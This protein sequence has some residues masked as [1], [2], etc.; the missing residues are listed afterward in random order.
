MTQKTYLLSVL[1]CKV[2]DSICTSPVKLT[3][4]GF[5]GI[6]LH[7]ILG[8]NGTKLR[9][10]DD[11]LLGVV[12]ADRQRSAD[13]RT[14]SRLDGSIKRCSCLLPRV[15]RRAY[16]DATKGKKSTECR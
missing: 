8:R 2:R 14:A 4:V 12:I 1:G 15:E 7:R 16:G 3:P 11:V 10:A 5:C 9:T 6:P 13:V